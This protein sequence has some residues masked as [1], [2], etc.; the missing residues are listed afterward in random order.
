MS[1][2]LV[3][4]DVLAYSS[5]FG[6]QHTRYVVTHNHGEQT[7]QDAK[8]RDLWLK[9][10][11]LKD[12]PEAYKV[13]KY[14]DVLDEQV[15]LAIC[16][17]KLDKLLEAMPATTDYILFLTGK[18]NFR[19]QVASLAPYKGNRT[20]VEK[21]VHFKVCRDWY[22]N[23]SKATVAEGQEA[24]D[25]IGIAQT[26]LGGTGIVAS[27]DKDLRQIHGKHYEWHNDLRFNVSPDASDRWFWLQML[28]GD[29]ADNIPGIKGIGPVKAEKLLA[30][31][32]SREARAQVVAA[33]YE[34]QYGTTWLHWANE[35]GTLL[36]IRRE[37]G[38]MFNWSDYLECRMREA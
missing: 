36:W 14:L 6:A 12:T 15:A 27:V 23:H 28:M 2:L 25:A 16:R 5:A 1:V 22:T 9:E 20:D 33:Q 19:D 17:N 37:E 3:D 38:Q 7:F 21:P 29:T 18:G 13:T 8:S 26:E 10:Q 35:V 4:A 34:K 32:P 24:D 30:G 31:L 11:G